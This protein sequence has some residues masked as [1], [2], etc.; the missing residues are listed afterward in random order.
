MKITEFTLYTSIAGTELM[1]GCFMAAGVNEYVVY[2][3]RELTEEFLNECAENWDYADIDKIAPEAQP[4]IRA[5]IPQLPE[6]DGIPD[7]LQMRI[8]QFAKE[9]PD[10]D[11]GELR[12]E[13]NE[14]DEEDWANNWKQ[15][16]KPI[17]IGSKL[18]IC[19]SWEP[20]PELNGRKLL[21]LDPGMAFGS[22]LHETTRM[23]LEAIEKYVEPGMSLIDLGCGSGILSIAGRLMGANRMTAVD[24]DPVCTEVAAKN[25]ELNGVKLNTVIGN[26]INDDSF[27]ES[28]LRTDA[29]KQ[30]YD[31]V[32]A[33]I[34]AGVLIQIAHRIPE[35]LKRGG[36]FVSSG[37]ITE[38]A[39]EVAQAYEAHGIRITDIKYMGE[40]AAI[41]ATVD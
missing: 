36:I 35:L 2:E 6:N 10:I 12:I 33:N 37:I 19:P 17:K 21:L 32:V 31:I 8:N 4:Y 26:V 14:V 1:A 25:A 29:E 27:F 16:Y 24:V 9:N 15:Y 38:R 5:Y 40:W 30:P 34:V 7:E 39:E 28:L 11:L 20:V 22:G 23:C 41:T 13:I 18:L 3:G